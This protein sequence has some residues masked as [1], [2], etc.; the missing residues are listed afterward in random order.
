M[1]EPDYR[2]PK[3]WVKAQLPFAPHWG[4]K[5]WERWFREQYERENPHVQAAA[6]RLRAQIIAENA[7]NRF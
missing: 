4:P 1:F 6:A 3:W 5:D 2:I 7:E